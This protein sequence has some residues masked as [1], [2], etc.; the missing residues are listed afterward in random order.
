MSNTPVV[1][2]WF[3]TG[4]RSNMRQFS[5]EKSG[6]TGSDL[7]GNQQFGLVVSAMPIALCHFRHQGFS[8]DDSLGPDEGDPPPQLY[9]L[10]LIEV[11][12]DWTSLGFNEIS[13][14][15][16]VRPNEIN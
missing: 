14:L 3:Q 8:A 16:A 11:H 6:L 12:A 15:Q 10:V 5:V 7:S 1:P 2:A 4:K 13:L 9:R